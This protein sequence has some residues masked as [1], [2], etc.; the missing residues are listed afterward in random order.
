MPQL[1]RGL[2]ATWME[3]G[4]QRAKT[5]FTSKARFGP[6]LAFAQLPHSPFCP[7]LGPRQPSTCSEASTGNSD[8]LRARFEHQTFDTVGAVQGHLVGH[9]G[10]L[11]CFVTRSSTRLPDQSPPPALARLDRRLTITIGQRCSRA[12]DSATAGAFEWSGLSSEP[13]F[14]RTTT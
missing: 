14:A 7:G 10:L 4:L 11:D 9:P 1:A 12:S 8:V 6:A 13:P 3:L 2:S 5:F